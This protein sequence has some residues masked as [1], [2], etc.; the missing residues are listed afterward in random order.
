M[1][2]FFYS[3]LIPVFESRCSYCVP[4]PLFQTMFVRGLVARFSHP[5]GSRRICIKHKHCPWSN[6][7]PENRRCHT[8]SICFHTDPMALNQP[9]GG[10]RHRRST[11][12]SRQRV[13]QFPIG[14]DGLS[15]TPRPDRCCTRISY[16]NSL[17]TS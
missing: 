13:Q 14:P 16:L 12:K 9:L 17:S 4:R 8:D 1:V 5:S 2:F 6:W 15:P 11:I 7:T 10:Y 3:W